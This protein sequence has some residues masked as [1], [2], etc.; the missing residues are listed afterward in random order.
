MTDAPDPRQTPKS[1]SVDEKGEAD[2]WSSPLGYS[3]EMDPGGQTRLVVSVPHDALM[4]VHLDL[5]KMVAEPLGFLYRQVVHRTNP[6]PEGSPPRDFVALELKAVDVVEAVRAHTALLHHDAR[7]E[8]WIRGA[9]GEQLV[10]DK[11][12]VLYCYPDDPSWED[13]LLGHGV[14]SGLEETIM[15]RDYARHWFHAEN[16]A[17]EQSLIRTLRL[18]E[19][20]PRR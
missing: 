1:T 10:L 12:G 4:R 20:P 19:V 15:D 17:V 5:I 14:P 16:D 9:M 7:C 8:L 3:R 2:G 13:V 6:R 18:V 11:D